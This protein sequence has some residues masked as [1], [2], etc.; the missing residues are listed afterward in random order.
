MPFFIEENQQL[1]EHRKPYEK[2]SLVPQSLIA[3]NFLEGFKMALDSL[4]SSGFSARVSVYDT[5]HDTLLVRKILSKPEV[6]EMDLIVGP[7]YLSSFPV[8]ATAAKENHTFIVSPFIQQ[9]SIISGNPFA[10]KVSP[11][12]TTQMEQ[13]AEYISKQHQGQNILMIHNGGY[14]DKVMSAAFSRRMKEVQGENTFREIYYTSERFDTIQSQILPSKTNL[15]VVPSGDQAFVTELLGKLYFLKSEEK[16]I[17]YGPENWLN[18]ENIE[19]GYLQRLNTHLVAGQ[20]IDY[21]SEEVKRFIRNYR[22]MYHTDPGSYAFQGYDT[23][24]FYASL[25]KKYG[26]NFHSKFS[27][28]THQGLQ[29]KFDLQRSD[30][31]SGF[32]NKGVYILKIEDFQLLKAE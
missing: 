17:V 28:F 4:R 13:L 1:H 22:K 23:G 11:A 3:V 25:L 5:G 14:S 18:F 30:D 16:I 24:L 27:N 7:F 6:K 15:I 26:T 31:K 32:E 8:A 9:N 29:I 19:I 12:L 2:E 10:G 20:F 21:S